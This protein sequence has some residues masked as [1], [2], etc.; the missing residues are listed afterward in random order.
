ML[1]TI[2]TEMLQKCCVAGCAKAAAIVDNGK[3]YCAAHALEREAD[4]GRTDRRQRARQSPKCH[5]AQ[6][7][8]AGVSDMK[9]CNVLFLCTGNS[10]RSILAEAILNKEGEGRFRAFSAGSFPKGAVHPQALK[11][12]GEFGYSTAGYR[13]KGWDEFALASAPWLDFVFTVCDA[14]AGETCPIWPG[15]PMTAHWGIPDPAAAPAERQERAFRDAFFAL[16]NRIRLFLTL[17][18]TSIDEMS[19]RT[20]LRE[21]GRTDDQSAA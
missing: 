13:S 7:S 19:L 9:I 12:L 16:Q 21:I 8:S 6:S 18:L 15:R 3:L 20:K 10:A 1:N 17:P 2:V 11:L 4:Q 14:A 5:D